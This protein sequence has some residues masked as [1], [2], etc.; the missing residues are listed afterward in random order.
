MG[1]THKG[2]ESFYNWYWG[3]N[4]HTIYINKVYKEFY[5]QHYYKEVNGEYM[6]EDKAQKKII[7]KLDNPPPKKNKETNQQDPII[8]DVHELM[9]KVKGDI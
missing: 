1:T 9:N 5:F 3:N 6:F 7:W 4:F 8:K 2:F